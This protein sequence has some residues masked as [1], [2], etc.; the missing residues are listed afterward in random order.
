MAADKGTAGY[1][2]TAN[3]ISRDYNFWLDDAFA[4]GGETG[5]DH[6]QQGITA[7]GA[8]ESVKRHFRELEQDIESEPFTVV[9]IGD[10]GGDVFGN[11][12]LLSRQ[13]KL[14]AAFNHQ[15]IFIDPDPDPSRSFE[16]RQRLFDNVCGWEEYDS[17]LL[18]PGGGIYRRDARTIEL[19]EEA[20][21]LLQIEQPRPSPETVIKR[22]LSAPADLLWNGGIGTYI[23]ATGQADSEAGDPDNDDCRVEASQVQARVIGEGGNLGITQKGRIELD[24]Q[25]VMLNT[26]AIDNSGGV[27]MSDHEVNIKIL[28]QQSI[29]LGE[30]DP[31][32]RIK[33]LK[34]LTDELVDIVTANNYSQSGVISLESHNSERRL[35]DY[36]HLLF[37]LEETVELNRKVEN[38]PFESSMQERLKTGEGMARPELAV[39]LSYTKMALRQALKSADWSEE[40]LIN[41]MAKDYFPDRLTRSFPAGLDNHPLK[42]EIALTRLT[43]LLVDRCGL[44]FFFRL[45]EETG[46]KI[47]D[48]VGWYL[49]GS[50]LAGE[51]ELFAE[52]RKT[53][54]RISTEK[55]FTTWW[56]LIA[57]LDAVT[58]W[59]C[60]NQNRTLSPAEFEAKFS[61][62]IEKALP[63]IR[64]VLEGSME[65]QDTRFQRIKQKE[66][67]WQEQLGNH[68]FA[69]LRTRLD[70]LIPLLD[71]VTLAEQNEQP[72]KTTAKL[73]FS[74]GRRLHLDWLMG[75]FIHQHSRD[76]WEEMAISS[77]S[78]EISIIQRKL[79]NQLQ[80]DELNL[81]QLESCCATQL[82]GLEKIYRDL[83]ASRQFNFSGYQ[84][85]VQRL[86]KIA[87]IC[88]S[89]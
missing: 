73:Y 89:S 40:W 3:Q 88:W 41:P 77:L 67:F 75:R 16:E 68:R 56:K 86:R 47:A 42:Q 66:D 7:R 26:D 6:K 9:G 29:R 39:I 58:G 62:L 43:N 21:S 35:D 82:E 76:H 1:S 65:E 85:F 4:S 13:I 78:R 81:K 83:E 33:V 5:Y 63:Q 53:E 48:L 23:K 44:S 46:I 72:V 45:T 8:W 70:Y 12:M 11:G 55:Y 38:L 52:F 49:V 25:G 15:H 50:R 57:R 32:N 80:T 19:S 30:L 14:V 74:L 2:D 69:R 59:L 79:V 61:P 84:F 31:E 87:E 28:L 37:K 51:P 24:Q 36:R 18:S 27:D 64:E 71:I 22:I 60:N 54:G 10:M 17:Q 34:S 20:R